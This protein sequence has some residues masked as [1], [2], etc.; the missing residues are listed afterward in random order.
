MP[1]DSVGRAQE[2]PPKSCDDGLPSAQFLD[3]SAKFCLALVAPSNVVA[4]ANAYSELHEDV[5]GDLLAT[6]TELPP[7]NTKHYPNKN[8]K[9]LAALPERS[10]VAMPARL[11]WCMWFSRQVHLQEIL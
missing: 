8:S 3:L 10:V 11:R 6:C 9:F 5:M 2:D 4:S 7:Q 1:A